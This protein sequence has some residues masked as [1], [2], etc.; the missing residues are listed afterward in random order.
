MVGLGATL[1]SQP[2]SSIFAWLGL[3][4]GLKLGLGLGLKLGLGPGSG[5]GI[6]LECGLE[7]SAHTCMV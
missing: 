7:P 6:G 1:S 3:G 2:I 5:F 4:L